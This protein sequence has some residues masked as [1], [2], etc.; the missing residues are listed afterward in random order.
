MVWH[1][2]TLQDDS[3]PHNSFKSLG[4]LPIVSIVVLLL[5]YRILIVYLVKPKKELQWRLQVPLNPVS[6]I[7]HTWPQE[8]ARI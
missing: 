7:L 3:D 5:T 8:V 6:T 1:P 4:T 2:S